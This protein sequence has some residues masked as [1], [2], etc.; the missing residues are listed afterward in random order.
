MLV[1]ENGP[2]LMVAPKGTSVLPAGQTQALLKS[3][4]IPGYAGGVGTYINVVRSDD[5]KLI[6]GIQTVQDLTVPDP[7][8][9]TLKDECLKSLK[10]MQGFLDS[11]TAVPIPAPYD[12]LLGTGISGVGLLKASV[13]AAGAGTLPTG[14]VQ[15][16]ISQVLTLQSPRKVVRLL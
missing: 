8:Y 9:Q 16:L 13:L 6:D 12:A 3:F 7:K 4:G 11:P 10:G 5:A 2:E 15:T 1:G 14:T